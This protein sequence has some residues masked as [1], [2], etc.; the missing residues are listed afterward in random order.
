MPSLPLNTLEFASLLAYTP[1]EGGAVGRRSRDVMRILKSGLAAGSPQEPF[2]TTVAKMMASGATEFAAVAAFLTSDSVLVPLPKSALWNEGSLWVPDQL[3]NALVQTGLG[4]RVA[5]LLFRKTAI[6]KAATSISS[7]RPTPLRHFE[8][9]AVQKDLS[10]AS[11]IVLVDDVITSGAAMLGSANRLRE[12]YPTTAIRGFAALRTVSDPL[13]F[14]KIIHPVVG[15]VA[16]RPNGR[17]H[18]TP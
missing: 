11:E 2:T 18:R 12:S 15:S 13:L 9:L 3:A 17:C 10:P 16:L 6:P 1:R 8:T 4:S 5:R 14:T 7:E